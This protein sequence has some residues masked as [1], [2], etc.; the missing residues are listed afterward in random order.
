MFRCICSK[1]KE[2]R[3]PV[4]KCRQF[5]PFH[6]TTLFQ[7]ILITNNPIRHVDPAAFRG[8]HL[9]MLSISKGQLKRFP[10][11]DKY[12][13]V[14][15]ESK[16]SRSTPTNGTHISCGW[17]SLLSLSLINNLLTTVPDVGFLQYQL[18]EIRLGFNRISVLSNMCN[19]NY[20]ELRNLHLNDN[21]II[22]VNCA[23]L[24]KPRVERVFP[25]R[26]CLQFIGDVSIATLGEYLK[27]GLHTSIELSINPIHY[28]PNLSWIFE[29]LHENDHVPGDYI[30][31]R[32]IGTPVLSDMQFMQCH[33]P[34]L[35]K[36]RFV[37]DLGRQ[38]RYLYNLQFNIHACSVPGHYLNQGW[39]N[40]DWTL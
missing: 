37:T 30:Y 7:T 36:G 24:I 23:C 15:G 2:T 10:R 17:D 27:P 8:T 20:T 1:Q 14:F 18:I 25:N 4:L 33:S 29:P 38:A 19:M 34:P 5:S 3:I 9:E 21:R 39:F 12:C 13:D 22:H 6:I 26:N 40:V 11:V 35:L 28:G 31:K 32:Q 16:W